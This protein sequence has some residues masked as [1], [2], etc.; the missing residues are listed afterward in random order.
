[1][2]WLLLLLFCPAAWSATMPMGD[3]L[4][5]LG[6]LDKPVQSILERRYANIERQHTDFSCGAAAVATILRYSYG[7]ATNERWVMDGMMAMA[8]PN[9]VKR[10]GFSMLDMKQYVQMLGMRARGYRLSDEKL[11]QVRVPTIVL[12]NIRGY[13]HFAVLRAIDK[14]DRVYLADPALGNRVMTFKEFKNSWN[15]ILLAVI[16]SGYRADSPLANPSPP[17]SVRGKDGLF[18]PVNETSLLEFGFQSKELM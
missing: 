13:Q 12:L 9:Q 17:L 14:Q 6:D 11:R 15:G 4:P 2:R 3:H 7:Q 8:D 1:M 10:Y 18:A 5:A 16:G